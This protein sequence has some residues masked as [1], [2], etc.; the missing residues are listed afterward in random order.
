M[1][2]NSASVNLGKVLA[3]VVGHISRLV[4]AELVLTRLE[5]RAAWRAALWAVG[6]CCAGVI[7]GL[8]TVV[9]LG[10][11]MALGLVA[12]GLVPWVAYLVTAASF[13][14]MAV[15]LVLGAVRLLGRAVG[16]PRRRLAEISRDLR[17]VIKALLK[18]DTE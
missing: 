18:G 7:F 14:V 3:Q 9:L 13:L 6:L 5:V 4:A 11:A 1:D 15:V 17:G 16:M 10:I 2:T 12:L 8:V